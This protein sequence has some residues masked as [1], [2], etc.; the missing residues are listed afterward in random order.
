MFGLR[1]APARVRGA[2][3]LAAAVLLVA[4]LAG[5]GSAAADSSGRAGL[6][7]TFGD[8]TTVTRCVQ[9]EGEEIS[10]AD[11]LEASDLSLVISR[12]GGL[13]GAVCRIEAEGC[14]D[15]GD[16]FC[17]CKGGECRYWSYYHLG[18]EGAWEYSQVGPSSHGLRDGDVDGWAWGPGSISGGA[19]PASYTFEEICPPPTAAPS[20]PPTV[21]EAPA[22]APSASETPGP[23]AVPTADRRG[24]PA[25]RLPSPTIE[26]SIASDRMGAVRGVMPAAAQPD[27][28]NPAEEDDGGSGVPGGVIAFGGV[29]GVLL[30]VVWGLALLRRRRYG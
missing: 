17:Q 8:G 6:V 30:A 9:F 23:T 18:E 7:V 24:S 11:L 3:P 10:G 28:Q 1:F 26:A 13:G 25:A 4:A 19:T 14:A 16:C 22:A 5:R 20:P 2:L 12:Y 21:T 29:A 15:P 27:A